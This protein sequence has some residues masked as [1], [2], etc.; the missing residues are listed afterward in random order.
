MSLW[1]IFHHM[2]MCQRPCL[3][4]PALK[5]GLEIV[6]AK[7]VIIRQGKRRRKSSL[8]ILS[9][10]SCH[11]FLL[12]EAQPVPLMRSEVAREVTRCGQAVSPRPCQLSSTQLALLNPPESAPAGWKMKAGLFAPLLHLP[13]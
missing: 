9:Y 12:L 4:L 3:V 7:H 1:C 13:K 8:E 5:R 11:L 6:L 10:L 2:G